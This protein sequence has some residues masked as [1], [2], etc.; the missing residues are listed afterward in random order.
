MGGSGGGIFDKHRPEELIKRIRKAELK[1]KFAEFETKLSGELNQL[2]ASYNARD[3]E[4]VKGRLKDILMRIEKEIEGS[5]ETLYGGSVAKH[6]YVDGLSDIDSLLLINK[7]E[8]VKQSP[9]N[10]LKYIAGILSDRLTEKNKIE[11]GHLAVSVEYSD[12]MKIQLL[13]AIQTAAGYKIA[14]PDGQKWSEIDPKGFTGALSK[15]NEKCNNKLVPTIKLTKAINA[16]FPDK[17][18]LTGYHIESLA[19]D[20]FKSYTGPETAASMLPHFF[21]RAKDLVLHSIKDKTGQ[22]I[23]VDDYLGENNSL[24]RYRIS[25]LLNRISRRMKNASAAGSIEQWL[26]L[27]GE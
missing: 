13:P 20:A 17:L 10:V 23:R 11:V 12:D 8:L 15:W 1:T 14:S 3:T 5:L 25:H 21:E 27:F 24:E 9:P 2:L 26:S 6:T 22:S 4:L 18:Q 19:V 16:Q 7:S